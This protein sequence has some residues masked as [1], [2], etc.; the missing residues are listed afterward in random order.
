MSGTCTHLCFP[1]VRPEVRLMEKAWG[2][3]GEQRGQLSSSSLAR[4][5]NGEEWDSAPP[6]CSNLV[7]GLMLYG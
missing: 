2:W 5:L 7:L 6:T 4:V 1:V 3:G